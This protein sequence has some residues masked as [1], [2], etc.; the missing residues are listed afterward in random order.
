M[1]TGME[2]RAHNTTVEHRAPTHWQGASRQSEVRARAR[3]A[4]RIARDREAWEMSRAA[5][6]IGHES[7]TIR[8]A[9]V[10]VAGVCVLLGLVIPAILFA[11]SH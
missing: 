11:L 9:V 3:E 4:E 10:F 7:R 8:R 6:P 2:I 5:R 1:Y